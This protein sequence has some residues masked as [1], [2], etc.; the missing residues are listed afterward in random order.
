MIALHALE[1]EMSQIGAH[2]DFQQN[3]FNLGCISMPNDRPNV[4]LYKNG[5]GVDHMR[6]F[7]C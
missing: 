6:Q 2:I 7:Q 3:Y 4:G 1:H 5:E